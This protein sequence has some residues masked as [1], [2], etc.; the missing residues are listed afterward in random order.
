MRGYGHKCDKFTGYMDRPLDI[1]LGITGVVL[2][3]FLTAFKDDIG[4]MLTGKLNANKDLEE[5]WA[6]TWHMRPLGAGHEPAKVIQDIVKIDRISGD[7]IAATGENANAGTYRLQGRMLRSSVFT[8]SWT[9]DGARKFLGGV[10]VLELNT[11]RDTMTGHWC[12]VTPERQFVGG[13][14]QWKK[15]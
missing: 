5:R 13:E 8:F 6:C 15:Q 14:V 7:K 2:T 10:A 9:G 12:E 11:M 4:L 3:A 1:I